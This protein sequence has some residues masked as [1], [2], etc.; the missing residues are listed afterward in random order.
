MLVCTDMT[1]THG[2]YTMRDKI[3]RRNT[4]TECGVESVLELIGG[5]WKGVILYH[6]ADGMKRFNQLG[7]LMPNITQRMLTRQL[8]E[9]EQDRLVHRKVYAEVPPRVEY[10]LT[11]KGE[12]LVP[13]IMQLKT[14]GEDNVLRS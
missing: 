11:E 12:T 2:L 1:Y 4:T 3:S 8:R 9:L 6:L 10:R 13:I 14:W 5:K 7:R